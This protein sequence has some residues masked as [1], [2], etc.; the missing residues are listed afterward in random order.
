MDCS[1]GIICLICQTHEQIH[2]WNVFS[3]VYSYYIMWYIGIIFC[4]AYAFVID[5]GLDSVYSSLQYLPPPQKKNGG[6]PW[7]IGGIHRGSQATD[8]AR[9][10]FGPR[11]AEWDAWRNQGGFRQLGG[12][13]WMQGGVGSIG[14]PDS[15]PHFCK[16]FC[17]Y[18][19]CIF[20]YIYIYLYTEIFMKQIP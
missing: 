12:F 3:D 11:S 9:Q 7:I 17:I 20:I 4:F 10:L 18:D 19:I 13:R 2:R 15:A 14:A 5:L 8:I 1:N 16:Y 6:F